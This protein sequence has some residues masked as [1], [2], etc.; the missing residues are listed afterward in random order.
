[1]QSE[2]QDI[3]KNF[4][5]MRKALSKES[6]ENKSFRIIRRLR[7]FMD[8]NAQ[9]ILFYVPINNKSYCFHSPG[10]YIVKIKPFSFLN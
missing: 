7:K 6:I 8:T 10:M 3:R 2:K 1:M 9:T 5:R 4:L